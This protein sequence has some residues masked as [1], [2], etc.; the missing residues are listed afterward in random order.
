MVL[1][2]LDFAALGFLGMV[3]S[4]PRT[5]QIRNLKVN[6]VIL[7]VRAG[8][9]GS[10]VVM[11]HGFGDTGDM[12]APAAA[13]LAKNHRVIVPD[14]RGMGLSSRPE[15]GYDKKTQAHDVAAVMDKP[16][17]VSDQQLIWR[18]QVFWLG[19]L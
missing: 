5:F 18:F 12:W 14:L 11:L 1:A 8:G 9:Q 17:A 16:A 19:L 3:E 2:A 10:A 13:V 15:N 6:G 7:S 4:F